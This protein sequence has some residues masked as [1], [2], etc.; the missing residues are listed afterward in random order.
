[1]NKIA[2]IGSVASLGLVFGIA[3]NK[4]VAQMSHEHM[5]PSQTK[6]TSQFRRIQQPLW[7][8]GAVTAGGLGLIGL[9]LWW[10]LLSKPKSQK[11]Q[12]KQGIQEVTITV[13]GGYEPSQVVVNAGQKVRLN[14]YR[15]DS[16]SCLE[17]IRLP[18]FHIAQQLPLNQVTPIEFTPNQPG[19]YTFT[20]GMNMFRGAIKVEPSNAL[21]TQQF[22]TQ[23]SA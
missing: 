1:M 20:C 3:S 16:S 14:F 17:E 4:A 13:D 19:T 6:Q 22:S 12:S 2:I 21:R 5:Q 23:I 10:F 7:V 9:E 15:K 11:A 8:K 18:D